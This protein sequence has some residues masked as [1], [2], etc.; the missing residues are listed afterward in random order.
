MFTVLYGFLW[1]FF[2]KKKKKKKSFIW[3]KNPPKLSE[4]ILGTYI[5]FIDNTIH[6]NLPSPDDDL[7]FM[8]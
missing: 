4:E 5:E 6:T 1:I 7:S 8:S 2:I 3:I